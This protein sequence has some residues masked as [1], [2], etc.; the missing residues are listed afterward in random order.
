MW[1]SSCSN[2]GLHVLHVYVL[3]FQLCLTLWD[4]MDSSPPGFSVNET[5]QAE[6]WSGPLCPPPGDL[7]NPGIGP[8]PHISPAVTGG[9][10]A[11]KRHLGSPGGS[12]LIK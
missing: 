5:L 1:L 9:V 7:L 2:G 8:V 3:L 10:F 6:Y 4:P 12:S 11:T